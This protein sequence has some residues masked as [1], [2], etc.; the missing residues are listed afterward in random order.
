MGWQ[1]VH[2]P[3]FAGGKVVFVEHGE[4]IVQNLTV[5][6]F[7]AQAQKLGRRFCGGKLSVANFLTHRVLARV[8][9]GESQRRKTRQPSAGAK[10]PAGLTPSAIEQDKREP[11]AIRLRCIG[12]QVPTAV[13]L[14]RKDNHWVTLWVRQKREKVGWRLGA[15]PFKREGVGGQNIGDQPPGIRRFEHLVA[16]Q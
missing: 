10:H 7:A 5:V 2:R 8:C 1:V 11:L 3:T 13:V 9:L 16:M 12:V 4:V 14:R 6:L 15:G